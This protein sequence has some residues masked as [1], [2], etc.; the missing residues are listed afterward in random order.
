M[1]SFGFPSLRPPPS[2]L[3]PQKRHRRKSLHPRPAQKLQ[4]KRLDLIVLVLRE[5]D[6]AAA[7][8]R[9]NGIAGGARGRFEAV[10]GAHHAN[11]HGTEGNGARAAQAAAESRP[12][13]G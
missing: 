12:A 7:L 11:F 2:A 13:R 4:Q 3:I 10:S 5:R 9:K 8:A 6:V 1:I